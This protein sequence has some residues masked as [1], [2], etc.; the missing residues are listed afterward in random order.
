MQK[1]FKIEG[2]SS[3]INAKR[4]PQHTRYYT[5]YEGR[6]YERSAKFFTFSKNTSFKNLI[7]QY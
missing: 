5:A 6:I 4:N 3:R 7:M 2:L 1:L